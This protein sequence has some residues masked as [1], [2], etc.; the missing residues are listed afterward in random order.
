MAT[1]KPT[2]TLTSADVSENAS[3]ALSVTKDLTV[4]ATSA[5]PTTIS[6]DATGANNIFQASGDA[7]ARYIYVKH[8][9]TSDGTVT[10]TST[11]HIEK[12]DDS[13]IAKLAADEF[14]FFPSTSALQLQSSSG[15]II[16][17]Y[18]YFTKG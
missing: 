8:T 15:N 3:L 11:L 4:T 10:T 2:L 12:T 14:A 1:L 13:E 6:V 16:A 17:E 9:G 18:A 5:M 7:Q